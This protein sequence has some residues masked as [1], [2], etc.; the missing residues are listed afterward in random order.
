M[1]IEVSGGGLSEPL[2]EM[3]YSLMKAVE[4]VRQW[5]E[6]IPRVFWYWRLR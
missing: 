5:R 3:S 1:D 4:G 6:D 2:F